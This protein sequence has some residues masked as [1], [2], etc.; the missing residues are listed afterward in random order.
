MAGEDQ[1]EGRV[2][3]DK[4]LLTRD[5]AAKRPLVQRL[6]RIEGQVRG[7]RGMIEEDRYCLD[8]IQQ[9]NAITAALRE[10]ALTII[11]QHVAAGVRL[12]ARPDA[13]EEAAIDDVMRVLRAAMRRE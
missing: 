4:I 11:G 3:G 10:V 7:L 13:P 1:I 5:E 12:A 8:E 9:I 2:D 6:N